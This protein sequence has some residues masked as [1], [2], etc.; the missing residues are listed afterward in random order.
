MLGKLPVQSSEPVGGLS[1][2]T[3]AV[4]R[5]AV[6]WKSHRICYFSK[7]FV[8]SCF[9]FR[10]QMKFY[11][12]CQL[13]Y[14]LH[15]LPELYFQKAKKVRDRA[16]ASLRGRCDAV[17]CLISTSEQ[18]CFRVSPSSSPSRSN[19][20][21][22]PHCCKYFDHVWPP[23]LCVYCLGGYSAPACVHLPVPGP[24]RWRLHSEVRSATLE[25]L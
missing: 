15:A 18:H 6:L 24:H 14:W 8:T 21:A 25:S 22:E 10:F 4:S 9:P 7:L 19:H 16:D 5:D 1:T 23:A 2:H 3:D 11:Y 17:S 12:I 13:G 20:H